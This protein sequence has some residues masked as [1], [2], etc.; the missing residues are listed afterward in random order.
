MPASASLQLVTTQQKHV[1]GDT[2]HVIE[3]SSDDEHKREHTKKF[4]RQKMSDR[5]NSVVIEK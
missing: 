5:R 2:E 4:S 1:S 3:A